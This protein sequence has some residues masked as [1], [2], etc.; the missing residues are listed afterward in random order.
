MSKPLFEATVHI[1][2]E[3]CR[4][5]ARARA[6]QHIG[7]IWACTA[8]VALGAALLWAIRSPSAWWLTALCVLLLLNV[9]LRPHFLAW[10]MYASRTPAVDNVWLGFRAD[11]IALR[12]RVEESRFAY[13]RITGIREND[14]YMVIYLHHHTPL[15][16]CK[17]EIT[18]GCDALRGFLQKQ[19]GLEFR[20][21][22]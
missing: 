13:D 4:A 12:S 14:D 8:A 21:L 5:L 17:A 9:L 11:G 22:G 19:T 1:T 18:G 20:S 6:S 7:L 3:S 10:R 2:P 15:I 16:L